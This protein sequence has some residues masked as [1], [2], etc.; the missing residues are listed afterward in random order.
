VIERGNNYV[1]YTLKGTELQETTVCHAEENEN[2]NTISEEI[3]KNGK[4]NCNFN[5]SLSPVKQFG[6]SIYDD[7]KSTLSGII[8]NPDF[9]RLV[10]EIFVRTLAFKFRE[11]FYSKKSGSIKYYKPLKSDLT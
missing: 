10:K 5:F 8:D 1:V 7:Q 2:I 11:L 4:R 9:A 3:F 6:F